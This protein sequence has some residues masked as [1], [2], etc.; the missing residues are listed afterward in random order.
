VHDGQSTV[1]HTVEFAMAAHDAAGG[2]EQCAEIFFCCIEGKIPD[3]Y[4]QLLSLARESARYPK[5]API[6]PPL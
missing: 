6:L 2:G 1:V 4:R 5:M 3:E